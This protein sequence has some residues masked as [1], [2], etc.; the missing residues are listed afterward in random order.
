MLVCN[1]HEGALLNELI[2]KEAHLSRLTD[3][4]IKM[5][6]TQ[7]NKLMP[8]TISPGRCQRLEKCWVCSSNDNGK[9]KLSGGGTADIGCS[10]IWKQKFKVQC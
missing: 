10:N 6:D 2:K 1:R 8:P 7:L 3:Y 9:K 5:V 4:A